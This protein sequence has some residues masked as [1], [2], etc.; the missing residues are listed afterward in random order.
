[1]VDRASRVAL[2]TEQPAYGQ[3]RVANELRRRGL[4]ISPAG[5]RCVWQRHDRETTHK[6]L[7]ALEAKSAQ[8]RLCSP[9][10]RVAARRAGPASTTRRMAIRERV[11]GLLRGTGHLLCR[12]AQGG[13]PVYQQTFIDTFSK[14]VF[15]K[16]YDRKDPI[17]AADLL[18]DR[19]V[20]FF[21]STT[22]SSAAC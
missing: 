22:S 18:N 12:H 16:L 19:V 13:R 20:P 17:T 7:K 11:P 5:V 4:T 21:A 10:P 14:V 3:V 2:A 6:R 8:G 9:K 1:M 15:A